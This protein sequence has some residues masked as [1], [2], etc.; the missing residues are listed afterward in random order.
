MN[1]ISDIGAVRTLVR[2]L[3]QRGISDIVLSPGSRNAPF[4]LSFNAIDSFHCQSILDERTA[5]FVALGIAQQK[6]RPAV[7]SCTSGSAVLNY[8][9]ALVEAYYQRIPLIAIT[10]D[11]PAAWIDQGEGQSIRQVGLL[12]KVVVSAFDLVEEQ[13]ETD[14]WYNHRLVNEALET[15]L[16]TRRPVQINVPLSEPLYGMAPASMESVSSFTFANVKRSVHDEELGRMTAEWEGAKR[17][18]IL[19]TDGAEAE[20]LQEVLTRFHDDTRVA[21]ISETNANLYHLGYIS[22]IDR[23]I[24]CFIGSEKEGEYIPDLLITIGGNV[25]SKKLKA[26]FRRHKDKLT[27]HWHFG[28]EVMDTFQ[29]LTRLIDAAPRTVLGQCEPMLSVSGEGFG[30]R[31]KAR[32]FEVE[33]KH[34]AFLETCAYSDLKVFEHLLDAIPEGS[35]LQMGN[36]SVVR[37]VQLFNQ[38]RGIRYFGNRGVS[39]IEGCTSTAVGA[40]QSTDALTVLISGDQAFRYDSNALSVKEGIDNL[41]IIVI[42][43]GGGSI[44]R[45]ID[46]PSRHEASEA[47]IEKK[48]ETSIAKLVAYHGVDYL[49]ASK[50]SELDIAIAELF[51]A[52]R[53]G[54][55]VL[56]V[57]TPRIDSPDILKLYFKALR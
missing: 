24:E 40:A 4:I 20:G 45:I 3:H 46:G 2:Q 28:G 48:D 26:L 16:K 19:A 1:E 39:G 35:A 12:D 50:L 57:F 38:I 17:I 15:A 11:R 30:T 53:N 6:G 51:A 22:C 47:F 43:N 41:R 31:W 13:S 7:L 54:A 49:S 37:Y 10:A 21:I 42:N 5:G 33:Q 23:T 27:H 29:S 44:F 52:D 32:F 55:A 34:A 56:E 8:A 14:Q 18:A 9:P 25:I 36:S